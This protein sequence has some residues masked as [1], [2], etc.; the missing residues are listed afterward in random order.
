MAKSVLGHIRTPCE[1]FNDDSMQEECQQLLPTASEMRLLRFLI[2]V[3]QLRTEATDI[4]EG[5]WYLTSNVGHVLLTQL[6]RDVS[7]GF[8]HFHRDG[9]QERIPLSLV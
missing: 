6:R 2:G 7:S 3:L 9:A 5:E 4:L 8:V 1:V